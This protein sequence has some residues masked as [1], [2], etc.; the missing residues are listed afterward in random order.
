MQERRWG[1][2]PNRAEFQEP[3]KL[4]A[5]ENRRLKFR[6]ETCGQILLAFAF[7]HPNWVDRE[8]VLQRFV[9]SSTTLPVLD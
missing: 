3:T 4:F 8:Q 6:F 5:Q 7:F 2:E 9:L 1:A